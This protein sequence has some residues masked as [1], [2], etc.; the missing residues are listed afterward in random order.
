M[1]TAQGPL[2]LAI[3]DGWGIAPPTPGNAITA[4]KTPNWQRIL[5]AGQTT[6]LAA[7]GEAVGL[8]KG[9]MG[10]SEVGHINIG[11]GRVV[12]QGVVVINSTIADGSLAQNPTLTATFD[13]L[14]HTGGRLHF[15][16]LL[17]D[18]SVHS[19]IAHLEALIAATVAQ[20]IPFVV[21]VI[22]DGR[23][24]PPQS[25]PQYLHRLEATCAALGQHDVIA[26]LAGR[27]YA[28]DRDQRW[29]RTQ[30]AYDALVGRSELQV[31][32]L[33]AALSA[34]A[35]RGETDEFMTPTQ[36]GQARSVTDGDAII[37]FN[38]R[39][40]RARQITLAFTR[41][42]FAHFPVISFTNLPFVS[43]T[44]Y[45]EDFTNPILF[46]PR[47]QHDTFGE[48]VSH[49]GLTQ[50]RLAETE[51]YAHVTYFFNGGRE[52]IFHGEDRALL[53]SDRSVA[54]YDQAPDMQARAITD[55]A[56]ADLNA[57]KHHVIIMNYANA[58]MVGHTGKLSATI[59]SIET[60]DHELGRLF[61]TVQALDGT[62][63]IT[64]DHGNAE[65]KL[66]AQGQPLTAHTTNPVPLVIVS[67][68]QVPPL[69][70]GGC[71]GDIAPTLLPLLGIPTPAA[72]TGRDLSSR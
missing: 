16:G 19:S 66:D 24:V 59:R 38:F 9:V 47:P 32:T 29:E 45:D 56:I 72:M 34:A 57:K 52:E 42:D 4:A 31:A 64:A 35:S 48:C 39:P 26:S 23:D 50:L 71:L 62:L 41:A 22:A 28:M 6:E 70:S 2:V 30:A 27:F 60:L 67:A 68:K 10:N 55:Y 53:P 15:F 51:K 17:S 11:S 20:R 49:A 33:S 5:A 14:R 46:G 44:R 36:I 40:D 63:V 13:H 69:Q 61:D 58:D 25:L 65:E 1:T 3:L 7:S 8:P 18:G 12:P 37:F 21:D 43:M 54:T